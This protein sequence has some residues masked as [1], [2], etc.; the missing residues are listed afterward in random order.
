MVGGGGGTINIC[1][2]EGSKTKLSQNPE[3]YH[4]DNDQ[5]LIQKLKA[6]LRHLRFPDHVIKNGSNSNRC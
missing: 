4:L 3:V 5:G 1:P 6:K 2:R